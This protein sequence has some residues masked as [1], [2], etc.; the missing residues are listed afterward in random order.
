MRQR[1]YHQREKEGTTNN[2]QHLKLKEYP[3][4][5]ELFNYHNGEPAGI[6]TQVQNMMTHTGDSE[7]YHLQV[8]PKKTV[9][10]IHTKSS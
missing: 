7:R 3:V 2:G 6:H 4:S 10:L 8:S 9:K 1:E 5:D